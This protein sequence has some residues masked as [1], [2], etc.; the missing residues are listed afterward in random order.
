MGI[1]DGRPLS[2]DFALAQNINRGGVESRSGQHLAG[3]LALQG[4]RARP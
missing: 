3:M 1:V 4:R 2:Y